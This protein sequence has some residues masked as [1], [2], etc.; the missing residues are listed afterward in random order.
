MY[1]RFTV[2][3]SS[4]WVEFPIEQK[5]IFKSGAICLSSEKSTRWINVVYDLISVLQSIN[6]KLI[7]AGIKLG[8]SPVELKD[9]AEA[10]IIS[11]VETE[12]YKCRIK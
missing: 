12:I 3:V 8:F 4:R 9:G 2:I 6:L 5:L 1:G 11:F 10:V 7:S